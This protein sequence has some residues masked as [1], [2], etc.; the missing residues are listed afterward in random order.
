MSF[1]VTRPDSPVPGMELMSTLCSAAIFRTKGV[2]LRWS[3]SSSDSTDPLPPVASP[4][5]RPSGA[6]DAAAGIV[7]DGVSS[8]ARGAAFGGTAGAGARGAGGA[9]EG[10]AGFGGAGAPGEGA[11]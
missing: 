6:A 11:A 4:T 1:F 10:V 5:D 2:D 3:R 8:L 7:F 9:P